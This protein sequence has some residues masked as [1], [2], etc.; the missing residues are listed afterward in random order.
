MNII[1]NPKYTF[2]KDFI[3]SLPAQFA[4]TGEIIYSGRNILK[5]YEEQGLSLIVKK[6]KV[7]HIINRIAYATIRTSKAQRSYCYSLRLLER[8]ISTPEPVAYIDEFF[9]GLRHSFYIALKSSCTRDMREFWDMAEI[10]DRGFILEAFGRFTAF[11][12]EQN[13]LHLDYSG[14]NI[15]FAVED[16]N[17]QFT[18]VDVNRIRFGS[19]S[20][21]EGYKNLERLWLPEEAYVIIARAYANARAFDPDHAVERVCYYK[22]KL[23]NKKK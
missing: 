19:V 17:P 23:M 11:V 13:V 14:G 12:H 1:I 4:G 15:M 20:E 8:G 6:F 9:L 18:L 16:Q 10:G 2:L 5:Q 21:E 3:E 22:N 7:P